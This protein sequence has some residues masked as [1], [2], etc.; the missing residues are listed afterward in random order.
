[1]AIDYTKLRARNTIT[2]ELVNVEP[3]IEAYVESSDGYAYLET[4]TSK[5]VLAIKSQLY[6]DGFATDY[7]GKD[8]SFK[9][10]VTITNKALQSALS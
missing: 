2:K 10:L 8:A 6:K 9:Q 5:E 7:T 4:L 3:L 1:M